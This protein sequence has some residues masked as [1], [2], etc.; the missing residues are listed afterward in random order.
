MAAMGFDYSLGTGG[1]GHETRVARLNPPKLDE[2]PTQR[3]AM[4]GRMLRAWV[5]MGIEAMDW[6]RKHG[7]TWSTDI[8]EISNDVWL[9]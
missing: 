9:S 3:K 6:K 8:E 5:E 2:D 4:R 7:M 1:E